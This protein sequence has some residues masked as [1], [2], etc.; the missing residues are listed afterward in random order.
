MPPRL[1]LDSFE[2]ATCC[3]V[4]AKLWR[5]GEDGENCT[6]ECGRPEDLMTGT[7]DHGLST[8]PALGAHGA[9]AM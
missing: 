4:T 1:W 8:G 6:V 9:I 3:K 2:G 7:M 5:D